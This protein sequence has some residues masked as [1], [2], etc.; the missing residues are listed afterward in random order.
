MEQLEFANVPFKGWI[1]DPDEHSLLDGP[2]GVVC[3]PADYG[4]IVHTD[5]MPGRCYHGHDGG[6]DSEMFFQ[7]S[8][9]VFADSS[10]YSSLHST[11]SYLYM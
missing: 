2:S 1:I 11:W 7:P 5:V 9:K 3:L 4:E 8:I 10:M 6:R